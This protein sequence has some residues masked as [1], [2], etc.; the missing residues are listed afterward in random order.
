MQ[1]PELNRRDLLKWG[2]AGALAAAVPGVVPAPATPPTL[3]KADA[4]ILLWLGGGA[5]HLDTFDPEAQGRRQEGGGFL[6]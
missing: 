3:G 4:C 1:R 2:A 6:L 5:A